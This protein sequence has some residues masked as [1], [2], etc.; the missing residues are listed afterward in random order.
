M[1]NTATKL[2]NYIALGYI[3]LASETKIGES[4]ASAYQRTVE[5]ESHSATNDIHTENILPIN[6]Q[7]LK[8]I[9]FSTNYSSLRI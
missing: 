8:T 5:E 4:S 6:N 7:V 2:N 3:C 1:A 9:D